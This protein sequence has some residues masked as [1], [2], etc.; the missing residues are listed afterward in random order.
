MRKKVLLG[1]MLVAAGIISQEKL[2]RAL[3]DQA[4]SGLRL[5]E[6]LIRNALVREEQIIELV[7]KQLRI[8]RFSSADFTI[9]SRLATLLA[10]ELAQKH[11]A[12]P[13]GLRGSVLLLVM[14]DPMD[15][16][17]L[18]AIEGS[19]GKEV[20]PYICPESEF[21]QL[22]ATVYGLR[23]GLDGL[24]E[25]MATLEV[26]EREAEELAGEVAVSSLQSMAEDAP[27]IRLVNSILSQ[28]VVEKASDVHIS[29][30][31]K[32]IQVRFRIDGRLQEVSAPPRNLHLA[33]VS[34]LKIL[35][36]MDIATTR[37]PQDGR[38]TI[39]MAK[40]EINVRVSTLPTIHG[41][42]VVLR[43]LDMGGGIYTMEE[44]GMEEAERTRLA[45]LVSKPYGMILATGP[46]GSGKS[47]TLYAILRELNQPEINIVTLE[48]PVEYRM[49]KIRQ[50]QLNRKAGMTFASGLRSIL[51]Q[52][53]DVV[54]VGEIRDRE[55]ADIAVQAALT[56]HRLLSTVHTND[57]AG[58]IT[59]LLDM[60]V[61]PFMIASSLLVSVAQRLVRKTCPHCRERYE[62]DRALLHFWELEQEAGV[63]FFRGAGCIQCRQ[64]GYAGRVGL[65]EILPNDETVQEL[66][67][68]RASSQAITRAMRQ[69]GKLRTLKED[70]AA[71]ILAGI[72]TVEE[73]TTA[74]MV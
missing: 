63:E 69:A 67:M 38:F 61:E 62:P 17:A 2:A 21:E 24:M 19:T 50:V 31:K 70:G 32:Y 52:D 29:P 4:R 15:I 57:A 33:L 40:R 56:G 42:N 74:V 10:P 34:R 1:E 45:G 58:A 9:D 13:L 27:V 3:E 37:I 16:Y 35:A 73:A 25:D 5:G 14:T 20:Q 71:K 44:L 11:R 51:R 55:T 18:D 7:S 30:E 8:P 41:E 26:G 36:N 72:T 23:T 48:D 60:G 12:V 46:T 43:L 66:I 64:T 49:E 53:P 6:Y 68:Q 54:M 59:R 47:T 39:N 28:A 65:Y 22:I